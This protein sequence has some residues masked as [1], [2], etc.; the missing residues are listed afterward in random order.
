MSKN[1]FI[2]NGILIIVYILF[3]ASCSE[4]DKT[5][6][7]SAEITLETDLPYVV[8]DNGDDLVNQLDE[9]FPIPNDIAIPSEALER[10]DEVNPD[11]TSVKVYYRVKDEFRN[12][13]SLGNSANSFLLIDILS[14]SQALI[15]S[16][17]I[18]YNFGGTYDQIRSLENSLCN[19]LPS[20]DFNNAPVI[21]FP[22]TFH[23]LNGV[24]TQD[25]INSLINNLN[26]NF[27]NAKIEFELSSINS[28]STSN[29]QNSNMLN[30]DLINELPKSINTLN[31]YI[32]KH[33]GNNVGIDRFTPGIASFP[34]SINK[35]VCFLT[36]RSF[37]SIFDDNSTIATHEFGHIFSLYHI[38]AENEGSYDNNQCSTQ[39][40]CFSFSDGICETPL[41]PYSNNL[42]GLLGVTSCSGSSSDAETIIRNYMSYSF[43]NPILRS[44]N[45]LFVEEQNIRMRYAAEKWLGDKFCLSTPPSQSLDFYEYQGVIFESDEPIDNI[46]ITE[47][48]LHVYYKLDG[49]VYHKELTQP[50]MFDNLDSNENIAGSTS[51]GSE[52]DISSFLIHPD[53]DKLLI[54]VSITNFDTQTVEYEL[55]QDHDLTNPSEVGS[56]DR[57][58]REMKNMINGGNSF[59]EYRF[60]TFSTIINNLYKTD[61]NFDGNL[62]TDDFITT[63]DYRIPYNNRVGIAVDVTGN[64]LLISNPETST[65][66]RYTLSSAFDLETVSEEPESS[67]NLSE[68]NA[69]EI[70]Y[71]NSPEQIFIIKTVDPIGTPNRYKFRLFRR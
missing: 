51:G 56:I 32:S 31:V 41:S 52:R 6:V 43:A 48:G 29:S 16:A 49:K 67:L 70:E 62:S 37:D 24:V 21:C 34:T 54:T 2:N 8:F 58:N 46:Y 64:S 71:Y 40:T 17:F 36:S 61:I 30:P 20:F 38:F 42:L 25:Q 13:F 26:I 4:D 66:E 39:D 55:I 27:S 60:N 53:G 9:A 47:N 12:Q 1:R 10:V 65:L 28:L 50:F 23:V 57:G 19:Q 11:S 59:L 44:C 33:I 7:I 35:G 68:Y 63:Q 5:E 18:E 15:N 69:S 45:R 14:L 3:F 22:V